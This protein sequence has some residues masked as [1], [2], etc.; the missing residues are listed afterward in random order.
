M[1][2]YKVGIIYS[3]IAAV[4]FL[5]SSFL[6]YFEISR[7]TLEFFA[8]IFVFGGVFFSLYFSFF[9]KSIDFNF[10]T[11]KIIRSLNIICI[12]SFSFLFVGIMIYCASLAVINIDNICMIF[13]PPA[14]MMHLFAWFPY[15]DSKKDDNSLNFDNFFKLVLGLDIEM[16]KDIFFS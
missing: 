1:R 9:I 7:N 2:I 15:F 8:S 4:A 14:L 10:P 5:L 6:S 13:A 16:R 3:L 12:L 11:L